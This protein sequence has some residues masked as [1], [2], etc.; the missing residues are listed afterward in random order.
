MASL[1]RKGDGWYCQFISSGKRHTF[2]IGRVTEAKAKAKGAQV[3]YL[4]MRL[5]QGLIALPPGIGV[6]E[7]MRH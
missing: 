7:F 3:E 5:K 2:S 6:V 4:L 1:Q